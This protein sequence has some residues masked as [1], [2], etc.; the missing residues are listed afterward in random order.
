MRDG[1]KKQSQK[2]VRLFQKRWV[3]PTLYIV[4]AAVILTGALWYQTTKDTQ[5]QAAK[6]PGSKVTQHEKE[7][8]PVANLTETVKMPADAAQVSVK[9]KFYEDNAKAEDQEQ[10]LVFY[11]NTYSAN[12]GID[13]AAKDGKA[14]DVTAA[15]S[16]TV[17]EA[18]KDALLGYVVKVDSGNGVVSFYQSMA[19]VKVEVGDSIAQGQVIGTAG[20][21][22]V[23]KEAGTHVHFEIR[24]DGVAVNP[25][26]FFD[27][28]A[29]DIKA[30]ASTKPASTEA[31]DQTSDKSEKKA[32]DEQST[33]SQSQDSTGTQK[34]E[35]TQN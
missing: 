25:E 1:E 24:K 3:F 12:T 13:L 16:G 31:K 33:D 5:N 32:A 30:D 9:K 4:C 29:A 20:L 14:F 27:K 22:E 6:K 8:T 28:S 10:A 35:S 11:N 2:V 26:K 15:L 17:T 21:S 34:Q 19:D 18:E 23:N 7:A